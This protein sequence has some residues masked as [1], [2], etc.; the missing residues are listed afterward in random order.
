MPGHLKKL[1]M[2]LFNNSSF[3]F[4]VATFKTNNLI[5]RDLKA[6]NQLAEMKMKISIIEWLYQIWKISNKSMKLCV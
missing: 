6:V 3:C 2:L 4:N 5:I 1:Q